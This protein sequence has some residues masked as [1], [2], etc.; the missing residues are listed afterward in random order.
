M[1]KK[2]SEE[3]QYID[4]S[5]KIDKIRFIDLLKQQINKGNDLLDL[6]VTQVPIKN[7]NGV[8]LQYSVSKKVD[9]NEEERRSFI[10]KFKKWNDF[11]IEV[12]KTSFTSPNSTYRHDYESQFI[13]V[14]G[15]DIIKEYKDNINRLINKMYSD[16]EKIDLIPS[17]T[18]ENAINND[19]KIV[20]SRKIFIVH[21]HDINTRTE[22]E[23]F[24]RAIGYEPI[25]LCKR[26]DMGNTIIEKIERESKDV[27]YAIVLYTAC[28][29]GKDK[30]SE[31]LNPRA[32]Q[33]VVFE[34]GFMCAKLG[35]KRV[36]ALLKDGVEQP[37]D[38]QGIIYKVIDEKGIWKYDIAKEMKAI[39]L[40]V[41][42]NKI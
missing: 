22:V 18:Q 16:I 42:L 10:D 38:V 29:Q 39:G 3:P 19:E 8:F 9:Y 28:D 30:D 17:A 40:L 27:C 21:G 12:Y 24:V 34:H 2:K 37:G 31:I 26:A 13:Y 7:S 35:R 23:N 33:N 20:Q 25:I 6:Q 32:R 5:L 11:N 15:T 36:V 4:A 41:D 14:W 1:A